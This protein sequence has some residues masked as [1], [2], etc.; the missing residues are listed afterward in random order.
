MI[1]LICSSVMSVTFADAQ[2]KIK[3]NRDV[4][5]EQTTVTDFNTIS[6]ANEFEVLLIKSSLPSVTIEADSNLHD[7]IDFQVNDSILNFQVTKDIRR[8]KAL[9]VIIRYNNL[10]NKLVIGGDVDVEAENT[11]ELPK[12]N[13]TLNDD[14]KIDANI[15]TDIFN[16]KNNNDSTLKLFTNCILKVES[17]SATLDLRKRSNNII[18]INTENLKIKTHDNADLDIEGFT[19]KLDLF[20]TNS[21]TIEGNTLLTNVSAIATAEKAKVDINVSETVNID[22]SGSSEINLY[23]EPKIV[24]DNFTNEASINKKEN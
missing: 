3:G 19:Y 20:S 1:L 9:K 16:L 23:G 6:I 24:I 18:D 15:M 12:F 22:A 2:S 8:S 21:S 13:L 11:I 14:A 7:A 10:L 4:R 5:T 17:K